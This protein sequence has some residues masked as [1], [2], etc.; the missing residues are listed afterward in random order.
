VFKTV[1]T[2]SDMS[3]SG[4]SAEETDEFREEDDM[5]CITQ[6]LEP[7]DIVLRK[8]LSTKETVKYFVGIIQVIGPDGYNTRFLR[9]R[10]TCW[11][12]CLPEI[13]DTAVE[14]PTELVWMLPHPVVS[15]NGR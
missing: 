1:L 7:N 12:V 6:P 5:E 3:D 13:E 11:A 15:G 14:D 10:L 4:V 9:K 2:D 8:L